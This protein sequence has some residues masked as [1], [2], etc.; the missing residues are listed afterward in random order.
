MAHLS[1]DARQWT[2]RA[3]GLPAGEQAHEIVLHAMCRS[4][5]G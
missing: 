2:E 3:A 5:A 1:E 4:C